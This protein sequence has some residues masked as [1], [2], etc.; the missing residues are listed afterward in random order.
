MVKVSV[1]M[2]T[3]NGEMYVERQLKTILSQL[4][5]GDELIIF[6]DNSKDSTVDI[7]KKSLI[8]TEIKTNLF[9]N[10]KNLGHVKNFQNAINK[11]SNKIVILS[12]QDDE[13]YAGKVDRIKSVL[14]GNETYT[15]YHHSSDLIDKNGVLYFKGFSLA[16]YKG[17]NSSSRFK[18]LAYLF[19][20]N[21]FFGCCI[22]FNKEK[23]GKVVF[24][25]YV[26]AHDHY[27]AAYHIINGKVFHD[28]NSFI[29]YRQHDNNVT[30]KS[31]L[32]IFKS[33]KFRV[34]LLKSIF[35]IW[36]KK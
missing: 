3:Y 12:D 25:K 22:A 32:P 9:V 1:C 13:W 15:L 4:L 6:D 33:I 34:D 17:Y 36:I 8:D 11:A 24:D 23:M 19:Y 5:S 28:N 26:Y 21:H 10:D 35:F 14:G 27:L 7:I 31:K 30:P 29:G 2:T 18:K 16:P 20:R